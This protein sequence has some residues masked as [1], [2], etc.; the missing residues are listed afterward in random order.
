VSER[1]KVIDEL[2]TLLGAES[3]VK[4]LSDHKTF[5]RWLKAQKTP[6]P[7]PGEWWELD[8]GWAKHKYGFAMVRGL[9][10]ED[11]TD[12]KTWP[13]NEDEIVFTDGHGIYCEGTPVRRIREA[14]DA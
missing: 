7:R 13:F 8:T 11:L 6:T 9:I 3:D 12:V 2:V 10:H 4:L 5:Y 1:N 14:P